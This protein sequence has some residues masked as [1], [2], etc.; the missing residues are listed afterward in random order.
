MAA[1]KPTESDFINAQIITDRILLR[2]LFEGLRDRPQSKYFKNIIIKDIEWDKKT[3]RYNNNNAM[4]INFPNAFLEK[5]PYDFEISFTT[6]GCNML[7]CYRHKKSCCTPKLLN[8]Y[9]PACSEACFAIYREFNDYLKEKFHLT[10]INNNNNEDEDNNNDDDDDN[11]IIPFETYSISD[12]I[13]D[14]TFCGIQLTSLK[15]FS[16]LPSSRWW[17]NENI[18][19]QEY[20]DKYKGNSPLQLRELAGLVD[21]PP[22]S[23]D[24]KTQNVHFNYQYCERFNKRF[25]YGKDECYHTFVRKGA[26]FLFGEHFTNM[27]PDL[28]NMIINGSLPFEYLYTLGHGLDIDKGFEEKSISQ[29]ELESKSYVDKPDRIIDT[30]YR[31]IDNSSSYSR[32][33]RN[34]IS[35]IVNNIFIEILGN[36]AEETG[37]EMALTTLPSISARLLKHYS[38]KFLQRALL[39]Q[40]SSSLPLS[41]RLFSL[42]ARLVINELTIKIATKMLTFISSTANI[43]FTITIITMIPDIILSYYNI[44]GYNN[45]ITRDHLNKRRKSNLDYL[46]KSN[47]KQYGDILNYI[48][49]ENGEYISPI[50]TPEF[51]YYL[52]L[53]NFIQYNPD[54]MIDICHNGLGPEDESEEIALDYIKSLTVN[55]IG[56]KIEYSNNNDS[57]DNDNSIK[58]D[59]N[60]DK[61]FIKNIINKTNNNDNMINLMINYHIDVYFLII[62]TLLLIFSMILILTNYLQFSCILLYFSLLFYIIWFYIFLPTFSG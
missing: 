59:N 54:K 51:M 36:I 6:L 47:V 8:G 15:T 22:L 14:K 61:Y 17:N 43:L 45:E 37:I 21:A 44:G 3:F 62:G 40:H 58:D 52:C 16:I 18:T 33:R 60:D 24:V 56:Q 27:F 41:I 34:D 1:A 25:N 57:N 42:T 19:A 11:T 7:K 13:K 49:L 32:R 29:F 31:I 20:V 2:K 53:L 39:V 38:S 10:N 9:I 12:P 30:N 28:D 35:V 23:W 5:Y 26:N 50:I 55:S 48:V 4:P 46:L